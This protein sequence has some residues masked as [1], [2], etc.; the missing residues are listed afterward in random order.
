MWRRAERRGQDHNPCLLRPPSHRYCKWR[1]HEAPPWCGCVM[2]PA[3][4]SLAPPRC[5]RST[6]CRGTPRPWRVCARW[7]LLALG[8][9]PKA[10][11]RT[12]RAGVSGGS[13]R[14]DGVR[15]RICREGSEG[16]KLAASMPARAASW[17]SSVP[18]PRTEAAPRRAARLTAG[19]PGEARPRAKRPAPDLEQT[20][21]VLG[22]GAGPSRATASRLR[23]ADPLD[24]S[25]PVVRSAVYETLDEVE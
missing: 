15:W 9:T 22:G 18:S 17:R 10:A 14:E 7:A 13:D 25:H 16:P 4:S 2:K 11:P 24:F 1:G 6:G 8:S 12:N 5:G 21:R 20:G 3:P 19:E 23:R